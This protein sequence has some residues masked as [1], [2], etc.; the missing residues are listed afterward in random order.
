MF[1]LFFCSV[2]ERSMRN[3]PLP[4]PGEKWRIRVGGD[5]G[6]F[7]PRQDAKTPKRRMRQLRAKVGG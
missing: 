4:I 1:V 3:E 2:F 5:A 6:N 7:D